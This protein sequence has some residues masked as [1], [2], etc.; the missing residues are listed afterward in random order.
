MLTMPLRAVP[1]LVMGLFAFACTRERTPIPLLPPA[2]ADASAPERAEV[3]AS[4]ADA[5][6]AT[7]ELDAAPVAAEAHGTA[8]LVLQ[9][10]SADCA[11]GTWAGT[12][13]RT[14]LLGSDVF[15][16]LEGDDPKGKPV[17][18]FA[19]CSSHD[20]NG[21]A[22]APQL[23]IWQNCSAFPS[24]QVTPRDPA[25]GVVEVT[26]GKEHIVL[27]SDSTHTILKGSFGEREVAPHPM[28][29]APVKSE[30]R[31]AMVDC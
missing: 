21:K 8:T 3:D 18:E 23:Q 4:V 30:T 9:K 19:F 24:C 5:A 15:V 28:K 7:K 26:C 20:K 10:V 14:H 12:D 22:R 1:Y 16:R 17:K 2:T 25:S 6:V 29:I 11:V 13:Q 31:R 27:E